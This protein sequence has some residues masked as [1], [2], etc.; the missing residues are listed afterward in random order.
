MCTRTLSQPG[1]QKSHMQLHKEMEKNERDSGITK[2]TENRG[3]SPKDAFVLRGRRKKK[4]N[5]GRNLL[6]S[7]SHALEI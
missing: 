6:L 7:K 5:G 4:E 2:V 1:Q 3:S